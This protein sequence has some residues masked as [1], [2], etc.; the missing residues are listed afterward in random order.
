MTTPRLRAAI[1]GH[2]RMGRLIEA[3]LL[4]RGHEVLARLSRSDDPSSLAGQR[5]DLAFEFTLADAAPAVLGKLAAARVPT[6]SGSTG[7]KDEARIAALFQDTQ[8]P[9]LHA[10]NFSLGVQL[11][12]RLAEWLGAAARNL[13]AFDPAIVE[14]HHTRK[15]DAPSGTAREL[16]QR[17]AIGAGRGPAIVSLRQGGQP[18]EHQ[19]ILDGP[20]ESIEI[21]HRARSPRIFAQGAVLAGEWLARSARCG[22]VPFDDFLDALF[23]EAGGR[24]APALKEDP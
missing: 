10:A 17:Y 3:E 8:T 21:V 13:P 9:Y 16:A 7:W 24:Q 20:E 4:A 12:L 23:A 5:T 18:G 15:K 6:I 14:R 2:G 19:L 22:P 11:V 1:V